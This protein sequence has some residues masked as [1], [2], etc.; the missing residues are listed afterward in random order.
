[1]P[2][3]A[4]Y[5]GQSLL[6]VFNQGQWSLLPNIMA[7]QNTAQQQAQANLAGTQL[8]QDQSREKFPLELEQTKALTADAAGRARNS[9]AIAAAH[10]DELKI[11][12]SV[13]TDQRVAA[14]LSS[15][16]RSKSDDQIAMLGNEME[17]GRGYAAAALANGGKMPL[18]LLQKAQVEHPGL[19]PYLT[20]PGGIQRLAQ[21]VNSYYAMAPARQQAEAVQKLHNQ[22]AATSAD[23][24][25]KAMLKGKQMEIDAGK[26]DHWKNSVME[27]Q[28][29]TKNPAE[30]WNKKKLEAAQVFNNA[31]DEETKVLARQ[32]YTQAMQAEN[33]ARQQQGLSGTSAAG[34]AAAKSPD[35]STLGNG[36]GLQGVNAPQAPVALDPLGLGGGTPQPEP[37]QN[38]IPGNNQPPAAAL[39]KLQENVPTTFG[40]GQT[41]TLQNGKPVRLK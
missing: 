39:A 28:L 11:L 25:A 1:M 27:Q 36:G 19:V 18:P 14:K 15:I 3:Q 33:V 38:P 12:Q 23:I 29:L 13:P 10:E 9:N 40:N 35:M 37:I 7:Q 41:W 21:T 22:G 34:V 4:Q 16:L 32:A 17:A 30:Y 24:T 2:T 8:E 31:P 20:Q 6:D 26:F 5:P